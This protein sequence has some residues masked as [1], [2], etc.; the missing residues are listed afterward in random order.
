MNDPVQ[1]GTTRRAAL[2]TAGVGML[3]AVLLLAAFAIVMQFGP[4][5]E[6][7]VARLLDYYGHESQQRWVRIAGIYLIPFAGISFIWFT[8][9]LREWLYGELDRIDRLFSNILLICGI[10]YVS[11]LFVAGAA[12]SLNTYASAN[13]EAAMYVQ[14]VSTF[15]RY[16]SSLFLIFALRMAAMI[17]FATTSIARRSGVFPTL[18]VF[19]GVPVGLLLLLTSS[20]NPWLVVVFPAWLT[21]LSVLL[22]RKAK[23]LPPRPA[24]AQDPV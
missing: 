22:L 10:L 5:D 1:S 14:V 16:G 20:L 6:F 19:S 23:S 24:A 7:S 15:S 2:I 13:L 17:V 21:A 3:H 4:G 12:L 8:V 11:M 18:F 9:A